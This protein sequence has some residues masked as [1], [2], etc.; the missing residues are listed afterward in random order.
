MWAHL[1][2]SKFR[3]WWKAY[4][5]ELVCWNISF[6]IPLLFHIACIISK[7]RELFPVFCRMP[8]ILL[9]LLGSSIL[10]LFFSFIILVKLFEVL[11]SLFFLYE[12][13]FHIF[14]ISKYYIYDLSLFAD[15]LT[16]FNILVS[17]NASWR[18]V[19][20]LLIINHDLFVCIFYFLIVAFQD[21]VCASLG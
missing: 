2:G 18:N 1:L 8:R 3:L 5:I 11:Q 21:D 14:H 9:N 19:M 13:F 15:F 6:L 12:M 10:F 20:M 7:S 4:F 16:V 17:K